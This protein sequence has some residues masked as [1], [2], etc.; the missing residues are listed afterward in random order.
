MPGGAAIGVLLVF[1]ASV[2]TLIKLYIIVVFT[3]FLLGQ[4]GMVRHWRRSIREL[5]DAAAHG[6]AALVHTRGL[7]PLRSD[8]DPRRV[9]AHAP[10]VLP[11]RGS[12]DRDR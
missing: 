5:R 9:G 3:S 4:I 2:T 1:Q 7:A 12:Q 10:A 11:E 8:P 6:H